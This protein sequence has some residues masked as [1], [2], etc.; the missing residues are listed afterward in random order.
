MEKYFGVLGATG[1]VGRAVLATLQGLANNKILV[2]A[3][4]PEKISEDSGLTVIHVDINQSAELEEFCAQCRTVI[5]C[6]GPSSEVQDKI[7]KAC[8]RA[9]ANYVDVSGDDQLSRLLARYHEEFRS[10]DLC[11]I[12][13]SGVNPGL[14]EFVTSYLAREYHPTSIEIYFSGRGRISH[15]A[16]ID[17]IMSCKSEATEGMSYL[18]DGV[19]KELLEF[20][21][22]RQLP[23]PS[24]DVMCFP[25]I[26]ESFQRCI[27]ELKIPCAYFYNTFASQQVMLCMAEAKIKP[28]DTQ[29]ELFQLAEDL[30]GAFE[31]DAKKLDQEFTAIH[32][33]L[34]QKE[35]QINKSFLY[36]GNWNELTGIVGAVTGI[37][38]DLGMVTRRGVGEI[39]NSLN[40]EWFLEKLLRKKGILFQ[41]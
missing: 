15:N 33:H 29:G 3:R 37:G 40:Y 2:G 38:V 16:S 10:R 18:K 6:I 8:L 21:F 31:A 14:T 13:S 28:T 34:H 9:N 30:K 17:M 27:Q 41:L 23:S 5:N 1:M 35:Q 39:W 19:T 7:A 22:E 24:G 32:V 26:N 36:N 11:C 25:V 20:K 12:H 4:N